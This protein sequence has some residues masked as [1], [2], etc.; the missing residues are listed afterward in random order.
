MT[1]VID[2]SALISLAVGGVLDQTL[3]AF[4]AVTTPTVIEELEETAEYDDRHGT[5]A[6]TVLQWTDTLTVQDADGAPFETSRVDA[7]EA[8]CVAVARDVDAAFLVTDDY[9]ALPELQGLVDAEVAVSPIVLRALVK[10]DALSSEDAETAFETIA[11]GRDWLDAPIYRY[12]RQ[13]FG[14]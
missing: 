1:V 10:R 7:G 8:S 14:E 13:L 11:S 3:A 12:A 6:T 4:D 2:T 9:R 5:A